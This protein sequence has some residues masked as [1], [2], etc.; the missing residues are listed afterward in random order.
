ML[1]DSVSK[2]QQYGTLPYPY[3]KRGDG[4]YLTTTDKDGE[5]DEIWICSGITVI[6]DGR[7]ASAQNWGR[8]I[9]VE[10]PDGA[11]HRLFMTSAELAGAPAKVF[12]RMS[13]YGLRFARGKVARDGILDLL[14]KWEPQQRFLVTNKTGWASKAC[15]AFVLD[16]DRVIGNPNVYFVG[17]IA[18]GSAVATSRG[19]IEAW[20]TDVAQRCVNNPVLLASMSLAFCGPLLDLLNVDS[21]GFHLRGASSCGKTTVLSAAISVWGGPERKALW[22][23]TANALEP[24]ATG[25]NST[26]LALDELGQIS[27]KDAFDAAYLLGNGQGKKRANASGHALPSLN[28]RVPVLSSGEITLAEKIAESGQKTMTGQEVRIIDVAADIG[29]FGAFEDTHQAGSPS[30]FAS[31]LKTGAE[32][33]YGL[34]GPLFVEKCIGKDD[35]WRSDLNDKYRLISNYF[36]GHL[37]EPADGPIQRVAANLAVAALAG[38]LA[39][40]WGLTGWPK[41]SAITACRQLFEAWVDR[42]LAVSNTAELVWLPKLEAFLGGAIGSGV[43]AADASAMQNEFGFWTDTFVFLNDLAWSKAFGPTHQTEAAKALADLGILGKDGKHFRAKIPRTLGNRERLYRL[44][45]SK[46]G[47]DVRLLIA[48]AESSKHHTTT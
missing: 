20:R 1:D 2:P 15:D 23:T 33:V 24:T 5:C 31:Q 13:N 22:R 36:L 39:T 18:D 17:G 4:I 42:H 19:N 27:G 3:S 26:L 14:G 12:S 7:D 48:A 10:D 44:R 25:M 9:E 43:F 32:T 21:F 35:K 45:I 38:E 40:M 8:I 6:G 47:A 28:W 37:S 41:H 34:A 11:T 29:R 30:E 46:L 16:A